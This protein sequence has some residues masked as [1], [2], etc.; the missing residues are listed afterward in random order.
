MLTK[1][2][3]VYAANVRGLVKNIKIINTL[4]LEDYEI[5][6]LSEIWNIKEFENAKI[7]GFELSQ[8]YQRDGRGGGV[9]I[10]IKEGL[11]YS[12]L[13]G[14]VNNGIMESVGIQVNGLSIY[15]V[16][17]P[18]SGN[19]GIFLEEMCRLMDSNRGRKV[20]IGGDFNINNFKPDNILKN[21]ANLYNLKPQI[22]GITRPESGSCLDNFFTNVEG[23]YWISNTSIADHLSIIAEINMDCQRIKKKFVFRVMKESNWLQFGSSLREL[24]INGRTTEE[25]WENLCK[26]IKETI[27]KC[28]PIRKS[29]IDHK[30][31]MSSGLL[32]SRDRKNLLLRR[33][34]QGKIDKKIYVDYN[35]VYRKLIIAEK[36][37]EFAIKMV[38]AG[39]NSKKK[40][41]TLKDELLLTPTKDEISSVRLPDKQETDPTRISISFKNH[42][43]TCAMELANNLPNGQPNYDN[44]ENGETWSFDNTSSAEIVKII[45]TLEPKNSCGHDLLSNRMLKKEISWFAKVLPQ[46]INDSMKEGIFPKVLKLA[47]IIPIFKKGEKDNMNNY[48][49]IALLPVMSKIFEKVINERITKILNDRGYIDENQYGFRKKHSTEDAILKFVDQIEKELSD[50]KH[51]VSVFVDVTKAFDSCDH[52]ILIKKIEKI[53]LTGK[54]LDVIK[55]YLKDREQ[56]VWVNGIC[57]GMYKIN[58]GVGQGTILGP[59][60]FKIYIMDLHKATSL[61]CVKFADDSNFL[62]VGKTKDEVENIV[63]TELKKIHTWFCNNKLTLHPGKSRFMVHSRDK[64]MNLSIGEHPIERVGYGL[65]EESVKFLGVYLDEKL[66]WK[67]HCKK[68]QDKI[69]KGNYLLWRHK[70]VLT[71]ATRK[72]IYESF[73]RCHLTYCL[74]IWGSAG[75]KNT[76]LNKTLKKI[77][78]KLGPRIRHTDKRLLDYDI[79]SLEDE[80]KLTEKKI[81]WKWNKKELPKGIGT[82]LKE[83]QD[84]NLR[85]RRFEM[86][87]KWKKTSIAYRLGKRATEEV[88]ALAK[89]KTS[90]SLSKDFKKCTMENLSSKRCLVRNCYI[91]RQDTP[92]PAA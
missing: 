45:R 14:I 80:L 15:C 66:D 12:K 34:K 79:I 38:N 50:K 72:I 1:A 52:E 9:A 92:H 81:I 74:S 27:E 88:A 8:W 29:T 17:R 68:V 87:R 65:Q 47:T 48:R 13:N 89:Y 3:K 77:I 54:S 33:Y 59:T 60:F 40:W 22:L 85:N 76:E 28:F 73:V 7:N 46:L 84:L 36:E 10:Y 21:W 83:K 71:K 16:Y 30:F 86:H 25:K 55:S 57:G 67:I 91:C 26:N 6:L 20:V 18:P 51:V 43:E 56:E 32:K 63:N 49:P 31:V 62:G 5:L 64:L 23:K 2:L 61:L 78:R 24:S 39:T 41:Q 53:G 4:Q 37:K 44:I 90:K 42:F 11:K 82:L 70:K 35:R 19:K 58:I 75:V 69:G